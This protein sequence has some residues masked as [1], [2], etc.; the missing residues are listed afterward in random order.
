MKKDDLVITISNIGSSK[1]YNLSNFIQKTI[2]I[3]IIII[4]IVFAISFFLISYLNK[5][6]DGLT[7]KSNKLIEINLAHTKTIKDKKTKIEELGG[8]LE[9]IENMIGIHSDDNTSLIQR[10]TL[11]QLTTAQKTYMM[12]VIPNGSPLEKTTV[13]SNF[14]WRKHPI[15]KTKKFHKG[16]DL[17]AKRKTKVFSTADGI[18]NYVQSKNI[19]QYGRI[20]RI[21]HNFGFET[22]FAHLNKTNVKVGDIVQK[23]QL[24]GYSGNSG[25]SSGPHLHYEL[26][27][28][29]KVLEPKDFIKWNFKNYK[30]IFQKQRR[31]EWE[32]L[33][34]IISQ[35]SKKLAQQ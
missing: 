20:V 33:I 25:R 4:A 9:N 21:H 12:Q 28:A 18:V 2:K 17:R 14:G 19:G 22:L 13:V 31:I 29:N 5:K 24:I 11:A 34:K 10:A 7:N 16:I 27:H 32:S 23:G 26:K 3:F 6:V 8:T 30:D 35:Q 15:T 1:S